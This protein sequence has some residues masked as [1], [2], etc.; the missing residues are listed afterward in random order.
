MATTKST[1]GTTTN[2][3]GKPMTRAAILRQ[4]KEEFPELDM[5]ELKE[6]AQEEWEAQHEATEKKTTK[7]VKQEAK[8]DMSEIMADKAAT[9]GKIAAGTAY[10]VWD[11]YSPEIEELAISLGCMIE[12]LGEKD[13]KEHLKKGTKSVI[14]VGFAKLVK[15]QFADDIIGLEYF[16]NGVMVVK[17]IQAAY[18]FYCATSR[19]LKVTDEQ[20]KTYKER[21]LQRYDKHIADM[22]RSY[23]D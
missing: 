6:M 3:G 16:T 9:V 14:W 17:G 10:H 18:H 13:V 22:I 23:Q 4:L 7:K 2:N 11:S 15:E 1:K 8:K 21:N 12:N 5:A 19:I 20:K